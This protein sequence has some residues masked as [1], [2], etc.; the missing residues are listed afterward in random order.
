MQSRSR[1]VAAWVVARVPT[2]LILALIAGLAIWGARNDWKFSRAGDDQAGSKEKEDPNKTK[3]IVDSDRPG[4]DKTESVAAR[5]PRIEFPSADAVRATGIEVAPVSKR[6]MAQFVTANGTLDYEPYRYAQ[7]APRAPGTVWWEEKKMGELVQKGEVLALIDSADVGRAKGDFLQSLA[8]VEIRKAALD[9]FQSA[10]GAV[11]GGNLNEARAALREANLRLFNDHQRLLNLNLPFRVEDV[12][13]LPEDQ[14]VRFLRLLGLPEKLRNRIDPETLT[15]NLLPLTA[16]FNGRL[17][18]H[19]RAAP[20]EVVAT[21]QPLFVVG[22]TTDLHIELEVNPEDATHLR[23]G[24][25]VTFVPAGVPGET[26]VSMKE[27]AERSA[28]GKLIHISPE[29]NEK[30]RRVEVHAEVENHDERLRPNTYGT[31]RILVEVKPG[32]VAVPTE[33]LQWDVQPAGRQYYVFV[34]LSETSFQVRPVKPGLV[35]GGFTQVDGVQ[36]GEKVVTT[37]GH[38]LK[39]ELLKERI[40]SED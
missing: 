21:N 4:E 33:A 32:A 27:L 20:G 37:G 8:Q 7:L 34:R 19:P 36:P 13:K 2:V 24:Q 17:L 18:R 5:Q 38:I 23:L 12:A 22:D 25:E 11:S 1:R 39:S 40:G 9:R 16:P 35:D 6:D 30:T 10:A 29:V 14:Q 26:N 28:H 15:A 31:G 3:V